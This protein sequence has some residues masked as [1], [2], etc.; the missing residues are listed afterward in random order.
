MYIDYLHKG[1]KKVENLK[2]NNENISG[3][4]NVF[5]IQ[6]PWKPWHSHECRYLFRH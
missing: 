6:S 4:K 2:L 5:Q 3:L 1:K